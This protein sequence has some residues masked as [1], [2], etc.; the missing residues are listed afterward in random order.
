MT[1]TMVNTERFLLDSYLKKT[2][3]DSNIGTDPILIGTPKPESHSI[4]I[5][6]EP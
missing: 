3:C 4:M 1:D 5:Q 6:T 2:T